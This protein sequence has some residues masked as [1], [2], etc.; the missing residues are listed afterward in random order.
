M[1]YVGYGSNLSASRFARYV[2]ECRDATPPERWAA[3]ELAHRLIF[4]RES[5]TWGGGGVAFLD[6]VETPGERTLGRAWLVTGE[7]F[8][9]VLAQECGLAVGS[10]EVPEG[11]GTAGL[12]RP[13][14]WYGCVVNLG[15]HEGWPM[16]TFTDE[17][18]GA[19]ELRPPG[20]AYR[21]VII[22]GL[23]ESHG[24]SLDEGAA[25]L[26]RHTVTASGGGPVEQGG[27]G[28]S[29]R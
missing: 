21:V 18:A 27:R 5:R 1:W 10:I 25:Y 2:A 3:V 11:I 4:A 26:A 9:D 7:Q 17:A 8:A 16:F 20:P 28:P 14:H 15:M 24:L 19:L 13:G 22:E 6:P 12:S 29:P 23:A